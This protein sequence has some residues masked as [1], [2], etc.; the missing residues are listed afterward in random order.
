MVVGSLPEALASPESTSASACPHS[1]P[2][3]QHWRIAPTSSA[4]AMSTGDGR[5]HHHHGAAGWRPRPAHELVLRRRQ[6]H[7]LAVV[8]FALPVAVGPDH[9]HDHVGTRRE[10]DHRGPTNPAA[11][12]ACSRWPSAPMDGPASTYSTSSR[13]G[14]PAV[15]S[16]VAV[17]SSARESHERLAA[18]RGLPVVD[19]DVT[20]DRQTGPADLHQPERPCTRLRRYERARACASRTRPELRA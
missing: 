13:C 8:A 7:R 4:H 1:S 12:G 16:I 9:A 17:T 20:V 5:V 18:A 3:N 11:R 2:A 10:R 14:S 15:S 19:D 6:R